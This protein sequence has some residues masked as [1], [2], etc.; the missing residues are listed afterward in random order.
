MRKRAMLLVLLALGIQLIMSSSVLAAS[1]FTQADVIAKDALA[2]KVRTLLKQENFKQLE[3]MAKEFRDQNSRFSEGVY[4]LFYFYEALSSPETKSEQAYDK[5][6][7][8]MNK[9]SKQYPGSITERV[10]EAGAWLEY[11]W[12]ARGTG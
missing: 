2:L 8:L 3:S 5:I 12:L 6:L 11:G 7:L 10:A 1:S 4:K 9:W